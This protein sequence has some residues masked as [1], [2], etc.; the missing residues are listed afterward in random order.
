MWACR[1]LALARLWLFVKQTSL[2]GLWHPQVPDRQ[3]INPCT[4]G[5]FALHFVWGGRKALEGLAWASAFGTPEHAEWDT[6][7]KLSLF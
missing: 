1:N 4:I 5:C 3:A 7:A 6:A 2:A